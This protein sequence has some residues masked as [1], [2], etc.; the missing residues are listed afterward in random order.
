MTGSTSGGV[1]FAIVAQNEV[2]A[3]AHVSN[4]KGRREELFVL[5]PGALQNSHLDDSSWWRGNS[6]LGARLCQPTRH[7]S[8]AMIGPAFFATQF[9]GS[10]L[11]EV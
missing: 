7:G 9:C 5:E 2:V 10:E 11:S 8:G 3:I 6:C 1:A 4:W